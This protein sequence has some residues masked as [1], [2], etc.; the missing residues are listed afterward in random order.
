MTG[1]KLLIKIVYQTLVCT[2]LAWFVDILVEGGFFPNTFHLILSYL[3]L[4]GDG[5][6]RV[7]LG[8]DSGFG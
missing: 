7:G 6:G 2:Y 5:V 1:K 4:T 3:F 8:V